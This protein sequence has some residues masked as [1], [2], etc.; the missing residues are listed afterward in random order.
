M[1]PI[2][3]I[4][5]QSTKVIILIL[6][7]V[8]LS[9]GVALIANY[10]S[11]KIGLTTNLLLT[12]LILI[13]ISLFIVIK[14][15]N[16]KVKKIIRIKAGFFFDPHTLLSK[17]VIGYKFNRD[18]GDYLKSLGV[19]NRAYAKA[20]C[21]GYKDDNYDSDKFDPDKLDFYNLSSS[22]AEFIFLKQLDYTPSTLKSV[23]N[24]ILFSD[25]F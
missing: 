8:F 17:P 7:A 18:M 12:G 20:L 9:L 15:I 4:K 3:Q 6:S 1:N 25:S 10:I 24:E 22:A 13:L 14:V 2:S 11:N 21:I 16:P 5:I 19:E 23:V